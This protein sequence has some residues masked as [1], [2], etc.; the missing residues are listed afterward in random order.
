LYLSQFCHRQS[1]LQSCRNCSQPPDSPWQIPRIAALLSWHL[2]SVTQLRSHCSSIFVLLKVPSSFQKVAGLCNL[3]RGISHKRTGMPFAM[4]QH[5]TESPAVCEAVTTALYKL[6]SLS[7]TVLRLSN[8]MRRVLQEEHRLPFSMT[9]SP[10]V[11]E[12][13]TVAVY[14]RLRL[15]ARQSIQLY[16]DLKRSQ[17]FSLDGQ[18]VSRAVCLSSS[19]LIREG[20]CLSVSKDSQDI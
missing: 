1:H 20:P 5:P 7:Q 17:L 11:Y 3:L 2:L 15:K 9:E 12:E 14:V 6:P 16:V 10:S 19:L 4:F 8:L 13:V 18:R